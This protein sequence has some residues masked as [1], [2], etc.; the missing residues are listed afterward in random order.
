M[1][2][3]LCCFILTAVFF[4][5][6]FKQKT[7]YEIDMGLEF[8]RVLFRS[9]DDGRSHALEVRREGGNPV[10]VGTGRPAIRRRAEDDRR[11]KKQ[12]GESEHGAAHGHVTWQNT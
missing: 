1:C 8:R 10:W 11:S 3:I 12:G 2:C 6:F 4:F 7:A 9:A 5:F